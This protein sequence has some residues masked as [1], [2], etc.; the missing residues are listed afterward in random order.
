M[1][2][3]P[4]KKVK[5]RSSSGLKAAK[6]ASARLA[7]SILNSTSTFGT[8]TF[9]AFTANPEVPTQIVTLSQLSSQQS[10]SSKKMTTSE[11]SPPVLSTP[12][13]D[14]IDDRKVPHVNPH[15]KTQ[16]ESEQNIKQ[17]LDSVFDSGSEGSEPLDHVA[18]PEEVVYL[19]T[20][21]V[22][23][24]LFTSTRPPSYSLITPTSSSYNKQVKVE[25]PRIKI[26]CPFC[27]KSPCLN[28]EFGKFIKGNL[29]AL[30]VALRKKTLTHLEVY[31]H[32]LT[33]YNTLVAF[34]VYKA[35]K[36]DA[37]DVV[38]LP[39]CVYN[40]AFT[41]FLNELDDD[42]LETI[43]D[44]KSHYEF[45]KHRRNEMQRKRKAHDRFRKF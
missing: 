32:F 3:P 15:V 12:S 33:Q 27:S 25:A 18:E 2:P 14:P 16:C 6:A 41:S 42:G 23:A 26:E 43:E 5:K 36:K 24:K 21:S 9:G 8:G 20:K 29:Q 17:D 7:E 38:P 45:I 13:T 39:Y 19:H 28:E 10:S 11:K 40:G 44:V 31:K 34:K 30:A 22:P 4:V 1:A 35:H 37:E